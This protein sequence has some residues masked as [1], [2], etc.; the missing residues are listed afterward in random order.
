LE[1]AEKIIEETHEK[2]KIKLQEKA[3]LDQM[4][5]EEAYMRKYMKDLEEFKLKEKQ[6][7]ESDATKNEEASKSKQVSVT[8]S[9]TKV[10]TKKRANVIKMSTSLVTNLKK[11][12]KGKK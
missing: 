12:A 2:Y 7:A 1:K 8:V 6:T 4:T 5:A 11:A 10:N 9:K 3:E